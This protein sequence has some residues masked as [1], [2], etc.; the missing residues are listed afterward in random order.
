M[1]F[2][3]F[4]LAVWRLARMLWTDAGPFGIFTKLRGVFIRETR[5][6]TETRL[7]GD[8]LLCMWCITIWVSMPF[9]WYLSNN[10][11]E[12]MAYT[13]ALSGAAMLFHAAQA[14]LE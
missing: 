6:G 14:R 13:G 8:M 1:T 10:F 3:I 9:A 2:V 11:V 12:F 4:S 7:I 5:H